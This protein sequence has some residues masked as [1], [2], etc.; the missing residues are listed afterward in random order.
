MDFDDLLYK[1][2]ILL[3]ENKDGVREKYQKLFQYVLVDEFQDTNYLQYSILKELVIYK[4]SASNL[5]VVGDDAQSIYAFRGATI[6]NIL[7]F[8]KEFKEVNVFKLEQNYRSTPHIV[9]A[10]NGVITHNKKQIK[11]TIWTDIIEGEPIKVIRALTDNEEGK[12]VADLI[13]EQKNRN[14]LSN[15]NI[16][17]LYRTNAQS[18]VFEEQLRRS[19]IPYRVFGGLSFYQRKEVKDIIAYMRLALNPSDD[20]AFKRVINYPKRGLGKTSVDKILN[21]GNEHGVSA[22]E[23]IRK[24]EWSARSKTAL[25]SFLKLVSS[26]LKKAESVDAY[27]AANYISKQS[28]IYD[29]LKSDKTVEGINRFANATSLLDGIKDFVEDDEAQEANVEAPVATDKSL[30]SYV[31]NVALITD[32]DDDKGS[33]NYI[34]LMSVHAAKGLEFDSVYVVGMEENLF[35]S[36]MSVNDPNGL[37]E[38]RRLFYVAITRAKRFLTLTYANSRYQFGQLRY[39][40]ASRFLDEVPDKNRQANTGGAFSF[41]ES[42]AKSSVRGNF[43]SP[44]LRSGIPDKVYAD[45]EPSNTSLLK[46]G[47]RVLHKKFGPGE[48]IDIG[49]HNDSR[50][51]TIR[52][53]EVTENPDRRIM[54]KFAKLL[55]LD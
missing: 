28:G 44:I 54:L 27:Q 52:F 55:I 32:A 34:S 25:S 10:A 23:S 20:E 42:N 7:D 21:Y 5:C 24:I 50:V 36:Y 40:D 6:D 13:V 8:Q 14:H 26:M 3:K 43:K 35:P 19:N 29:I 11:K 46:T 22:W 4:D 18:R 9:E 38:E 48:V 45:F 15:K 49:G 30:A 41:K 16:A 2:Y 39:N 51:A 33:T 47:M 31:Q 1:M 53:D 37:D 12:R 17:I